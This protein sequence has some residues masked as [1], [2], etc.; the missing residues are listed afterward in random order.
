[1]FRYKDCIF[2][3]TKGKEIKMGKGNAIIMKVSKEDWLSNMIY[4][5]E[6]RSW[7]PNSKASQ[8][9]IMEI[10][11]KDAFNALIQNLSNLSWI[12]T[13]LRKHSDIHYMNVGVLNTTELHKMW[14]YNRNQLPGSN[15]LFHS[16]LWWVSNGI[17][18]CIQITKLLFEKPAWAR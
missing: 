6:L 17:V 5:L 9:N 11:L 7:K 14:C 8:D 16:Q 18:W 10:N 4:I 2:F 12:L 13:E 3:W 15:K 1:M